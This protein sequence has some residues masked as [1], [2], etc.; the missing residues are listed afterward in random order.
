MNGAKI[1]DAEIVSNW[2]LMM[3]ILIWNDIGDIDKIGNASGWNGHAKCWANIECI[4][5]WATNLP[6]KSIDGKRY[7]IRL[8]IKLC[9][10]NESMNRENYVWQV[11]YLCWN[12][13]YMCV[14]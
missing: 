7:I 5:A 6:C 10:K 4:N 1:Y 12:F 13:W 11:S 9:M 14:N 2:F 3:K 8:L